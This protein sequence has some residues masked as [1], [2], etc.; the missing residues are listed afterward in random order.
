M[1][2]VSFYEPVEAECKGATSN[3]IFFNHIREKSRD[4]PT[5]MLPKCMDSSCEPLIMKKMKTWSDQ[6][7]LDQGSLHATEV[8]RMYT[9]HTEVTVS[10][11]NTAENYRRILS[12]CSEKSCF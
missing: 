10:P 11:T 7:D 1:Q 5:L 9:E 2:D 6:F 12:R 8:T 3:T 4:F